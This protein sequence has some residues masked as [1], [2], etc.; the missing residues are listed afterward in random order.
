MNIYREFVKFAKNF[1]SSENDDFKYKKENNGKKS[2]F[3]VKTCKWRNGKLIATIQ[4]FQTLE[5]AMKQ[6]DK[7]KTDC[8]K[9][10]NRE[11]N[12]IASKNCDQYEQIYC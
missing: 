6:Y 7:E 2:K 10:Y 8:V 3:V 1:I 5:M 9:L 12:L 11:H 4:E